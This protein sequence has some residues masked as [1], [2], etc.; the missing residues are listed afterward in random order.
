MVIWVFT[1]GHIYWEEWTTKTKRG[2]IFQ[3]SIQSFKL[4]TFLQEASLLLSAQDHPYSQ[5][6]YHE[7]I[8][9]CP[10]SVLE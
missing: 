8:K 6:L 1:I 10:T 5:E 4:S 2:K 3:K 7:I 9:V